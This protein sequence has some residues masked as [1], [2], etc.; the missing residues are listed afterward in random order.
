MHGGVALLSFRHFA[1]L[2]EKRLDRVLPYIEVFASGEWHWV[3]ASLAGPSGYRR[4][5]RIWSPRSK[6]Q[7]TVNGSRVWT[8]DFQAPSGSFG[9]FLG[10]TDWD[11]HMMV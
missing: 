3:K 7:T 5:H 10:G 2:L 4:P 11:D 9:F 8:A 1:E 6:M